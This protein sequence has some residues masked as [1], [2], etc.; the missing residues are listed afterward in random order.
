MRRTFATVAVLLGV[1]LAL[2]LATQAFAQEKAAPKGKLDRVMGTVQRVDKTASTIEVKD[3]NNVIR[4]VSFNENTVFTKAH[5]P[6]GSIAD[7]DQGTR[8]VCVGKFEGQNKLVA[9]KINIRK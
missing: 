1:V 8:V 3:K 7:L 9:T 2:S 5:K 6:G 4:V